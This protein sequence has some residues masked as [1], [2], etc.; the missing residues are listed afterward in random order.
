MVLEAQ[1]LFQRVEILGVEHGRQRRP[2]DGPVL[3][4]GVARHVLRV[5]DLL[6]EDDDAQLGHVGPG[7]PSSKIAEAVRYQKWHA[8]GKSDGGRGTR[9]ARLRRR[10]SVDPS[11]E[12]WSRPD[13]DNPGDRRA[14][15]LT[16][17]RFALAWWN[18]RSPA[19]P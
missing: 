4:H 10:R 8:C 13:P 2:V 17:V 15:V 16:K 11:T 9:G 14:N 6:D 18:D 19:S 7:F 5:R 12:N 1:R 3:L